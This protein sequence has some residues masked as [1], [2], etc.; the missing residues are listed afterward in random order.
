MRRD[1]LT[2]ETLGSSYKLE[3]Q[4]NSVEGEAF[5]DINCL[6]HTDVNAE[7]KYEKLVPVDDEYP[8]ADEEIG[9]IEKVGL[10]IAKEIQDKSDKLGR[11]RKYEADE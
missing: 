8:D 3:S 5:C 6:P 7:E 11:R 1:R 10:D 9:E 4:I 2:Q